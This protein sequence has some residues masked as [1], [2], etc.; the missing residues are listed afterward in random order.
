MENRSATSS[1][2]ITKLSGDLQPFPI[3]KNKNMAGRHQK[4]SGSE[5][6]FHEIARIPRN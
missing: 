1:R 3:R 6:C 5:Y 4:I 2:K